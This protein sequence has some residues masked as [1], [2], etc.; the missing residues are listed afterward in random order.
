MIL[1]QKLQAM[2]RK[3]MVKD[4]ERLDQRLKIVILLLRYLLVED[5]KIPI[6]SQD[7]MAT[8]Q[9]LTVLN[10]PKMHKNLT[11]HPIIRGKTQD[12]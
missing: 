10:N 9:D 12:A 4:L 7:I 6:S 3:D 5:M 2:L 1:K 11:E 8:H